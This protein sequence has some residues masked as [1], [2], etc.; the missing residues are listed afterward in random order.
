LIE[1]SSF[2][3]KPLKILEKKISTDVSK[4]EVNQ[5]SGGSSKQK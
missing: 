3:K 5:E 4:N 1:P 2:T